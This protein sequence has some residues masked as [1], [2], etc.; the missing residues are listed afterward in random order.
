MFCEEKKGVLEKPSNESQECKCK[1]CA[2]E[3]PFLHGE[4]LAGIVVIMR[5]MNMW[6]RSR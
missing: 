1:F 4:P 6:L 5:N 3:H 2:R